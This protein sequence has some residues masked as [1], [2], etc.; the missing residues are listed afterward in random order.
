MEFL[1]A[2]LELHNDDGN[3]VNV[4]HVHQSD[5]SLCCCYHSSI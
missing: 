5:E 3:C 2:Y 1:F 4:D